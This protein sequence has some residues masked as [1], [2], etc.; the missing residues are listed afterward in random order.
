[1]VS[2]K[3]RVALLQAGL[4]LVLSLFGIVVVYSLIWEHRNTRQELEKALELLSE[5]QTA[6]GGAPE[7]SR[8]LEEALKENQRLEKELSQV[9]EKKRWEG[10]DVES[11]LIEARYYKHIYCRVAPDSPLCPEEYLVK[12][13]W[14]PR[15]TQ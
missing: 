1:M 7:K 9:K 14:M 2:I 13:G 6:L 15:R 5:T 4:A 11:A 12:H 3:T 10:F 8:L